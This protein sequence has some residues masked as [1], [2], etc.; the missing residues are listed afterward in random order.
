MARD[1]ATRDLDDQALLSRLNDA[2]EE[3]F[4]LRFQRAT[5]QLQSSSRIAQVKRVRSERKAEGRR[6]V[7]KSGAIVMKK[8]RS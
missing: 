8:L 7:G 2:R 5:G 4:N 6:G 3:L 1:T